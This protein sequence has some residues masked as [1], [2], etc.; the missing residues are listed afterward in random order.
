V[1]EGRSIVVWRVFAEQP[2]ALVLILPGSDS[3][4][5]RYSAALPLLVPRGYEV[6]LMDYEGYGNSPGEASLSNI[7]DDAFA[8]ASYALSLNPN[9]VILA[10][11]LGTPSAVR[12]AADLDLK[13]IILEGT[14]LLQNQVSLWLADNGDPTL[15]NIADFWVQQQAPDGWNILKYIAQVEEPKLFIH[16]P[17]DE[18]TPY[19]GGRRVFDAA[20][21][22]KEFWDVRGGHG[23]MIR[24]DPVAYTEKITGFI[25]SAIAT[26]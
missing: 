8:A 16:S 20:P 23:E 15:G 25:E 9:T 3:N 14:L 2:R 22:P 18:V 6:V 5:G 10:A 4:K 11:S 26:P 7:I 21:E 13:G 24:L 1:A 12:V 17:E 19:E